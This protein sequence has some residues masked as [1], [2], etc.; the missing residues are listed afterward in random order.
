MFQQ[1]DSNRQHAEIEAD[2]DESVE[3]PSTG[4]RPHPATALIPPCRDEEYGALK[5]DIET[6]GQQEPIVLHEGTIL[7]GLTRYRACTELGIEPKFIK[8]AGASAEDYV[9]SKNLHRRHLTPSQLAAIAARLIAP[10]SD[11]AAK[12]MR[13][14]KGPDNS[15]GRARKNPRPSLAEGLSQRPRD[16]L[17]RKFGVSKTLIQDALRLMRS[18][19][20]LLVDVIAGKHSLSQALRAIGPAH[21]SNTP[22]NAE[23]DQTHER[24]HAPAD[25]SEPRSVTRNEGEPRVE[26]DPEPQRAQRRSTKNE[27]QAPAS[28][29]IGVGT[30]AKFDRRKGE[31]TSP[32]EHD[33][34][35]PPGNRESDLYAAFRLLSWMRANASTATLK[36]AAGKQAERFMTELREGRSSPSE[37]KLP[38]AQ[39]LGDFLARLM[40]D[41]KEIARI[42]EMCACEK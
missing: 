8:Y 1:P 37:H 14:G 17:A 9:I 4:Y 39:F 21:N 30:T 26:T 32:N 18:G 28:S 31:S 6:N 33:V 2:P 38:E 41:H 5:K 42:A 25:R 11:E 27:H 15:G 7:D 35:R 36:K 34:Q 3:Q 24:P 40:P 22:R 12:R 10:Y 29:P 20:E 13:L 19:P 16:I 23:A